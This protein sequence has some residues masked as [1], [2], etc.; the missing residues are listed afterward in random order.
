MLIHQ[1]RLA[2]HHLAAQRRFYHD[3]L[4]LPLLAAQAEQ[5]TLQVGQSTLVFTAAPDSAP[6]HY[7]FAFN[8][9]AGQFA[10]A[11]AWLASRVPLLTDSHGADEFNF[12]A[13][14]AH[15]VYFADPDG[16]IGELIARYD[17]P[18]PDMRPFS[19]ASLLSI[20][21][22]GLVVEDVLHFVRNLQTS[23]PLPVYLQPP[24]ETFTPMGDAHGLLIVV[25][26]GRRWY[27][28][29]R[30]AAVPAPLKIDFSAA[31]GGRH[32]LEGPPYQLA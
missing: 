15:A 11:K 22:I 5:I 18:A 8:I 32:T 29:E 26:T 6:A 27:P 31:S 30:V 14:N 28:E 9:P 20:S 12:T 4:G 19:A 24:T 23:V 17:L 16:N 2:T 13:W 25:K 7:H 21:E 10:E 3:L 1:L